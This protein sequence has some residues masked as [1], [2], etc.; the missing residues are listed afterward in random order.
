[1][2][3]TPASVFKVKRKSYNRDEWSNVEH[4]KFLQA[5]NISPKLSDKEVCYSAC[6]QPLTFI[7]THPY[8]PILIYSQI[9]VLYCVFCV[10]CCV[11]E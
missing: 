5:E 6:V 3:Q 7:P 4:Q 1:M 2:S 11:N 9:F 10:Y 8:T